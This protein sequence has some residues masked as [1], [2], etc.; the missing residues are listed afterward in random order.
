M[1]K[2]KIKNEEV[3]RLLDTEVVNFPKYATQLINLAN[4]NAQG[5]RP[6]IVGQMSELIKQ[7]KGKKLE[8]WETWYLS[9]HPE[10]IEKAKTRVLQMIEN[11]KEVISLIDAQMVEAWVKDLVIIKTFVGLK[12]QE[13]IIKRVA[14]ITNKAY[15]TSDPEDEAK[16]IDGYI[17]KVPVSVKPKTYDSKQMLPETIGVHIIYYEKV[18]DGI[19]IFFE[20]F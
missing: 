4:Q 6:E 2:I 5:T 19:N 11:F 16:G 8:E 12:F 14:E 15:R 17:G 20:E 7:F 13:A 1:K 10:A 18:K 3:T 9:R